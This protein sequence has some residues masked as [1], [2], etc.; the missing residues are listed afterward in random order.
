MLTVNTLGKFQMTDGMTVV[1]DEQLRSPMLSKLLMYMLLYREKTLT[2]DDISTAIWQDEEIDNPA[3]ALKNLMYRLRKTLT[4]FFGEEDFIVTN[5]GSYRWN[6]DVKVILDIEKFEKLINEAKVENVYEDAI[7][8]YEQAIAIYQGDFLPQILDMHWIL[9]L[10][11]YYH[12]LFLSCAK[13]LA[14]LYV[15]TEQYEKLDKLCNNALKYENGDEQL[16][17]YQIEARMRCGKISLALESYEKAR[18]IM[19]KELGIRKTT[20]LNKV[21]EE[22]LAMSKGQSAYSMNEVREDI[23]EEEPEGVFFCGYPIFKEIYHLEARKSTRAKESE[24]LLLLTITGKKEDTAELAQFRTKQAMNGM[25][26][27][28]KDSLR[29]GDVA[30]KYSDTQFIILLPS[31]TE[32]LALLVANRLISKLFDLDSKYK[33]V[34]V[35]VNIEQ[36]SMNGQF[37]Q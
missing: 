7:I 23:V 5:R 19:E 21:Y 36:V 17:C 14:E 11:T 32:E 37:V 18:E 2:T 33:N 13:G 12:S 16:F 9:T 27:T 30:A 10:N 8:K 4:S 31:T 1:D 22:L 3:G 29:V 15:K 6:P 20:I 24:Y 35:R 28:I 25:E 26:K 34:N